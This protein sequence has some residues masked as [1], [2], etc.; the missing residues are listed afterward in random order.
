[1]RV[2]RKILDISMAWGMNTNPR[3]YQQM[4]IH[5][6]DFIKKANSLMNHQE[7]SFHG[8]KCS[9]ELNYVKRL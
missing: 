1:M 3:V 5:P 2:L 8:Y 6:H 7:I 9:I 4:Q